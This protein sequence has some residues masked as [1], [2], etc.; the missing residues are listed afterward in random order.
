VCGACVV[1]ACTRGVCMKKAD[2]YRLRLRGLTDWDA[3]LLAECGLPGPGGNLELVQAVAD[4]GDETLFRGYLA[5]DPGLAPTGSALEFL[6]ICGVVGLGRLLAE[7]RA[8][9]LPMIRKQA[10]DPRWRMREGVAMALQRLGDRDMD[11]LLEAVGPW[12]SGNALEQKAAAAALCEPRLLG[13]PAHARQVLKILDQITEM[14]EAREDRR[15]DE[16]VALRKGLSYCW[17]VVVAAL[18]E[19]GKPAMEKWLTSEDQ[20]IRR[21]MRENLKKNRLA[22]MDRAWVDKCL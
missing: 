19:E 22:R 2:E 13:K 7:G 4:E 9:L 20:E 11:G 6:P 8:D 12:C 15:S 17:S 10:S 16:F 21:I 3:F 14:V 5:Y 1:G 18:P